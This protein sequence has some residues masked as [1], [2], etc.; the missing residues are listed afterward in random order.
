MKARKT[1]FVDCLQF[2]FLLFIVPNFAHAETALATAD[3]QIVVV[4]CAVLTRKCW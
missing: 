1:N 4:I 3:M 2:L